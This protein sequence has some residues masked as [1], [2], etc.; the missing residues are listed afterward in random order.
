M[1]QPGTV[2]NPARGQLNSHNEIKKVDFDSRNSWSH[3][4]INSSS[5]SA[6]SIL[7]H[8][9]CLALG[10]SRIDLARGPVAAS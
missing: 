7:H 3:I 9:L 2:A 8:A 6:R 10:R 1:D 4:H 5:S